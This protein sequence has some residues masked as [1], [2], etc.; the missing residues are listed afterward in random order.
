MA[1]QSHVVGWGRRWPVRGT[2]TRVVL[3]A[4]PGQADTGVAD[5][6]ALHLI[7]GH[8]CSMTVDELDEAAALAR[9]NL[10]VGDLP[11]ALEKGTELILGNVPRESADKNSSIVWVGELIHLGSRVESA[12]LITAWHPS[13][14]LLLLL[15][16]LLLRRHATLHATLHAALHV[17][18]L[19]TARVEAVVATAPSS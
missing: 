14:H 3:T 15:L 18:S 11:E 6:V 17:W 19:R 5:G 16:L 7:D 9:R 1:G 12:I 13:P 10:D 4:T 8:L 2:H